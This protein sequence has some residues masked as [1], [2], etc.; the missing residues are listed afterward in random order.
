MPHQAENA[1]FSDDGVPVLRFF[2]PRL[3]GIYKAL[4]RADADLY[5]QRNASMITGVTAFFCRR[6]K[7]IFVFGAGSDTDLSFRTVRVDGLRDRLFF[8]AGLKMASGIVAQNRYQEALC[9]R[10]IGKPVRMIANG[11]DIAAN[12]DGY[13]NCVVWIGA[14]RRVKQP[15]LFLELAR[16]VPEQ[17]FLMIGG[18]SL[19]ERAFSQDIAEQAAPIPNL[20]L[21]GHLP[22]A[23]VLEKLA[24]ASLL[25]N[26]SRVE[27]F[28][29]AY[30]EAWSYGVP[31]VSFND[32]D[33]LIGG[34]GLGLL[35]SDVDD[36]AAKVRA[37]VGN[38]VE[39]DA[40]RGRALALLQ[41]RFSASVLVKQYEAFFAEL[42]TPATGADRRHGHQG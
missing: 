15:E 4:E 41:S 35:C 18:P 14:I 23:E 28:P 36:M 8:Y 9:K 20:T 39:V 37:L 13:G 21:T 5:Y 42:A 26:T 16:R 33:D 6:H 12:H 25:A 17:K 19:N 27:G 29:N 32:V 3:P 22:R 2:Y 24:G 1:Y 11:V 38:S 40:I 34:E 7:R 31:V 30:L 10:N